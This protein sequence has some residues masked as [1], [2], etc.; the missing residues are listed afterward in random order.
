MIVAYNVKVRED[1]QNQ[2]LRRS[3]AIKGALGRSMT[4]RKA[5]ITFWSVHLSARYSILLL[6][7]TR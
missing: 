2:Q 6:S 5:G 3:H 4:Y 1:Q 7:R